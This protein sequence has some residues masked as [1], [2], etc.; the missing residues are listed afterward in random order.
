MYQVY[1]LVRSIN[2]TYPNNRYIRE[3]DVDQNSLLDQDLAD[4]INEAL[5]ENYVNIGL[6]EVY[7][8]PTVAGQNEYQLPDDCEFSQI[9]EVTRTF[10]RGGA[11]PLGP[12]APIEVIDGKELPPPPIY[13]GWVNPPY[14]GWL[15][16]KG[17]WDKH[18]HRLEYARDAEQLTGDRYFNAYNGERIGIHPMPRTNHEIV[19]IYYKKVPHEVLTMGD[20]IEI[21]DKF[22]PVITY[23]VCMKIAISGSVPDID[24]YNVFAR[25]YNELIVEAKREKDSDQP[26]YK[27]VKDNERSTTYF[28]RRPLRGM[29][30]RSIRW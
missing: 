11:R 25:Q 9:E 22:L 28:R 24:M 15:P 23:A 26:F 10:P 21:E 20:D 2:R 30:W 29:R 3:R 18:A 8:F 1:R 7:E 14:V 13:P 27:H 17:R 12:I 16:N 19:T 4:L 6:K 5:H